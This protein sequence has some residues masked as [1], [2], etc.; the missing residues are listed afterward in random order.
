[1]TKSGQRLNMG[2]KVFGV[3]CVLRLLWETLFVR[4]YDWADILCLLLIAIA[5]FSFTLAWIVRRMDAFP[6]RE[7]PPE[8]DKPQE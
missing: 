2:L 6:G 4:Y 8:Q 1:M 7:K 5:L 3:L